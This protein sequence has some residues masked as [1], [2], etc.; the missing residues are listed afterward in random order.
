MSLMPDPGKPGFY[1]VGLPGQVISCPPWLELKKSVLTKY[2]P[3][4]FT[5]CN[6]V[7]ILY[8]DLTIWYVHHQKMYRDVYAGFIQASL[9]KIQGL[10][11]DF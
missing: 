11:K 2:V 1:G 8:N 10:F 5:Q 6:N 3:N 7:I 4:K 9:S